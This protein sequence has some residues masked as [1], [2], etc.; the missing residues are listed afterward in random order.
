MFVAQ[1]MGEYTVFTTN[2]P[3]AIA[4]FTRNLIHH[5]T[6]PP[7]HEIGDGILC[8][9]RSSHVYNTFGMETSFDKYSLC[10]ILQLSYM[11]II[12]ARAGWI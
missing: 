1:D 11:V 10:A 4:A 12:G 2:M 5:P 9:Q 6:C 3:C 7:R 8:R